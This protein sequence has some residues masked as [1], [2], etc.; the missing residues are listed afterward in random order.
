MKNGSVLIDKGQLRTFCLIPKNKIHL[1]LLYA[2]MDQLS[3]GQFERL[4]LK[5]FR[6]RL[7]RILF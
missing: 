6:P 2:L 4:S 1:I 5:P 3:R 7:W